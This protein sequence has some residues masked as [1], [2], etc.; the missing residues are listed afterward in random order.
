MSSPLP[1]D[2][3]LALGVPKNAPAGTIK[4]QYRKLVL[5]FHPD[6]VQDESQKQAA[7]DQFHKIQTAYE[8]I[9]DEERRKRYDAQ[10]ELAQLRKDV[11]NERQGGGGS[12]RGSPGVRTAAYKMP[13][14]R[15]G[16][17]YARGPERTRDTSP[18]YEERRPSYAGAY[19]GAGDYFDF[20]PR[21][22]SR[23]DAEY[24]RPKRSSPR[25]EKEKRAAKEAREAEERVKARAQ[26]ERSRRSA[27]D[28]R[29]DRDNK[30]SPVVEEDDFSDT[31]DYFPQS[32]KRGERDD[33]EEL[34]RAADRYRDQARR[35]KEAAQRGHYDHDERTR[36]LYSQY[37]EAREYMGKTRLRPQDEPE[38]R[39]PS[40][41]RASSN[42]VEYLK[43]SDGRTPVM[44]RRG[45]SRREREAPSRRA[46][47][48]E[49]ARSGD[50]YDVAPPRRPPI[51]SQSKSSP[52]DIRIPTDK[53]RSQSMQEGI[54]LDKEPPR[55]KRADS[56]PIPHDASTRER[57]AQ[58]RRD[59]VPIK[60]S[61][62]RQTEHTEGLPTPAATPEYTAAPST[63][64][65]K[66]NPYRY[67]QEYADDN[68]FPTPDG[69]RTE[70]RHPS[71]NAAATK[72][73]YTRSPERM[74]EPRGPERRTSSAR[75]SH[76]HRPGNN[77]RT[78]ST[79]Y[80]YTPGQGL[81]AADSPSAASATA[82]A[83]DYFGR[84]SLSRENSARSGLYGE[85]TTTATMRERETRSP[86]QN[87]SRYSPPADVKY[88][89]DFRMED[90][91][92][93]S[94][95]GTSSRGGRGDHERPGYSRGGSGQYV[96]VR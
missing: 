96:N 71:A 35:E 26:K 3:Y 75:Y 88:Q 65:P 82:G 87:S 5:K 74:P 31:E 67:N 48:W 77:S 61:S 40:P 9:G 15:S 8:I 66:T 90:V 89:K 32:R 16:A 72:P 25:E 50:E 29:R 86:R 73:R 12:M 51:L 45:S 63:S 7:A 85:I 60:G 91:R 49:R 18:A 83:R 69:Y 13:T 95:Y 20:T 11:M 37:D 1:P 36:K 68:E 59:N 70:V 28:M 80:V 4:T 23:K 81:S 42:K 79:S 19:P 38:A 93:Q 39:R 76:P 54:K 56:M 55:V 57:D 24:D 92:M 21:G 94:G 47:D 44:V 62:L 58:R 27:R 84:P 33:P 6:K 22:G 46:S 2:P 10:V 17:F 64:P 14:E 52:A 30:A 41:V 34:R 78:T 43:R 53:P